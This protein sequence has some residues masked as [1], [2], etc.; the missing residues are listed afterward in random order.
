LKF[1]A[2]CEVRK[3]LRINKYELDGLFQA[4]SDSVKVV[5]LVILVFSVSFFGFGA[6]P[7]I[8]P[9]MN[10][11]SGA[12]LVNRAAI[13]RAERGEMAFRSR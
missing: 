5:T 12:I 8:P 3:D 11:I 9:S 10:L 4:C 13:S 2:P 6:P 1:S 7:I